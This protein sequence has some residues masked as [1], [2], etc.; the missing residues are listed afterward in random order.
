MKRTQLPSGG[1]RVSKIVQCDYKQVTAGTQKFYGAL[2]TLEACAIIS[3]R[4]R[5][6]IS[7]PASGAHKSAH[8]PSHDFCRNQSSTTLHGSFASI[9]RLIGHRSLT[10]TTTWSRILYGALRFLYGREFQFCKSSQM[11]RISLICRRQ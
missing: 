9:S 3:Q 6:A 4:K 8:L 7:K 1:L 5:S 2:Q 11:R 10:L